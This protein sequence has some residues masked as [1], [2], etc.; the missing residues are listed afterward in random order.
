MKSR[1]IFLVIAMA[2]VNLAL[3]IVAM[4]QDH[5]TPQEAIAKA[6]EAASVLSKGGDL[7]QFK[8]KDGQ[9]VWKDTYIFIQDCDKKVMAAHPIK[10]EMIGQ[11]LAS[12]K[13]AKTGKVIYPDSNAYCKKVKDTPEGFWNEYWWPKPGEKE[14]SR[15]LTY[16]LG[17]KG[18]PY[19]VNVGIYDD[20]ASVKELSKLTSK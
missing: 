20:K 17:A 14:P 2:V 18:T 8:Q 13:D 4:G 15:K 3:C 10:P 5:A 11:D 6:R 12:V 19:V 16:H 9:W 1:K 7:A